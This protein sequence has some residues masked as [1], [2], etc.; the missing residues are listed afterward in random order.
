MHYLLIYPKI[1]R[2]Q[3]EE[4]ITINNG[5]VGSKTKSLNRPSHLRLDLST[6]S[7]SINQNNS[8]L[9][10][11][12][13]EHYTSSMPQQRLDNLLEHT[14]TAAA[15][16]PPERGSSFAVMSQALRSPTTI[17]YSANINKNDVSQASLNNASGIITTKKVSFQE[18]TSEIIGSN[19]TPIEKVLEDPNVS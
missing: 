18:T 8:S 11:L 6:S 16:S 19:N 17:P 14:N 2:L 13:P 7:S 10:N 15:P 1:L 12:Y 3:E 9:N 4:N 5:G